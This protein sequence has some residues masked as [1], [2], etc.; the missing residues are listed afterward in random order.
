MKRK[1]FH[2]REIGLIIIVLHE[3]SER[4]RTAQTFYM[5]M[6][7]FIT[8]NQISQLLSKIWVTPSKISVNMMI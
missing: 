3:T 4:K 6:L 2:E 1:N 8:L 5:K 7:P